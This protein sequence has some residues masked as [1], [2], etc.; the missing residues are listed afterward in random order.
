M[1]WP[2]ICD[3]KGDIYVFSTM[4]DAI[5]EIEPFDVKNEEYDF[6]DSDGFVVEAYLV[7]ED[8]RPKSGLFRLLP[9]LQHEGFVRFR[10]KKPR[11]YQKEELEKRLHQFLAR[12]DQKVVNDSLDGLILQAS[13]FREANFDKEV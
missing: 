3:D 7:G 13:N 8:C 6:F 12:C 10:D 5:S 4:E 9:T 2:L 1:K 11:E